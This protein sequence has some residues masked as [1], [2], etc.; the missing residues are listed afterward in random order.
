MRRTVNLIR[1]LR[2]GEAVQKLSFMPYAAA[3]PVR[4]LLE[5]AIANARTNHGFDEA[6]QLHISQFCVDDGPVLKRWRAASK[7]RAA[8]ILKR[9][10]RLSVVLSE[11]NAAD[12]ARHIAANSRRR[13]KPVTK[14]DQ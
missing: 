3:E 5:S 6:E 8:S 2:A 1:G 10:S 13:K 7:G 11:L 12:Y 4:K 14:G 9:S